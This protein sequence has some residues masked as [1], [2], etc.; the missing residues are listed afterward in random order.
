MRFRFVSLGLLFLLACADDQRRRSDGGGDGGE[1][2][3]GGP[4]T[5]VCGNGAVE[6]GETCDDAGASATCNA[7]CT[8]AA[9]GD[10]IRNAA[11]GELCDDGNGVPDD[12][13][14]ACAPVSFVIDSGAWSGLWP[15]VAV[16]QDDGADVFL[17]AYKD[18]VGNTSANDVVVQKYD[19]SAQPLG[20]PVLLDPNG[21]AGP[22]SMAAS[23]QGGALVAW[24]PGSPYTTRW[25]LLDSGLA[26]VPG[27]GEWTSFREPHVAAAAG[28]GYCVG[29]FDKGASIPI[30]C[31]DG[32]G[33][34]TGQGAFPPT[35]GAEYLE[36]SELVSV[37]DGYLFVYVPDET[38]HHLVAFPLGADGAQ[39]NG[40][41]VTD[42]TN[43]YWSWVPGWGATAGDP[44]FVALAGQRV[45]PTAEEWILHYRVY[46]AAGEPATELLPVSDEPMQVDGVAVRHASGRFAIFWLG[47]V[48]RDPDT[49]AI[50]SCAVKGR[51]YATGGA[52]ATA[53]FTLH[54]P[55]AQ[56][57]SRGV[58]GA[59][60]SA[61]NVLLTWIDLTTDAPS[62][63]K[64]GM[65]L[66]GLLGP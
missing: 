65:L 5:P 31:L 49:N 41:A 10:G 36:G 42:W 13:C 52:P 58:R 60:D 29:A 19:T 55:A 44:G 40:F 48:V 17:V 61:G 43:T 50:V 2:G 14:D 34:S 53:V 9:C 38:N 27:V 47:D 21:G 32:Q 6:D 22:V 46:T 56:T 15:D 28:G 63:D 57:C 7:D 30:R 66:P 39:Q 16:A 25:R 51:T 3:G 24:S 18:T 8:V 11:A 33:G 59:V 35:W 1:G 64:R 45:A 62:A 4:S 54:A 23:P 12:G 20:G 37:G 26:P